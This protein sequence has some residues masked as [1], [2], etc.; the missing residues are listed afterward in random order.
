MPP[1]GK[2]EIR[3][4]G[5][6]PWAL[7]NTAL[8]SIRDTNENPPGF[9][10]TDAVVLFS[11]GD[12]DAVVDQDP[13]QIMTLN[14]SV[15]MDYTLSQPL[16]PWSWRCMLNAM[17]D[18]TLDRIVGTGIVG[19]SVMPIQGSYDHARRYAAETLKKPYDEA[20]PVPIWDFVVTRS[21][22]AITETFTVRVPYIVNTARILPGHE[23]CLKWQQLVK[24]DTKKRCRT[25]VDDVRK[26]EGRRA[27]SKH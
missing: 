13:Y 9:P 5:R 11:H 25:W 2:Q 15:G 21:S 20:A 17:K 27:K 18:P 16:Q 10:T 6:Q 1:V 14:R 26:V 22:D 8:K 4:C 24:P 3:A 7:H 19:V 23:L 12:G